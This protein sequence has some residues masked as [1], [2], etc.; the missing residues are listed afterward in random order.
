[1][2]FDRLF[3]WFICLG[4]YLFCFITVLGASK[5][6]VAKHR[7]KFPTPLGK[8]NTALLLRAVAAEVKGGV[9]IKTSGNNCEGISCDIICFSDGRGFDVLVDSE[10]QAIPAWNPV[11]NL[12]KTK[13]QLI[14]TPDPIPIP[15]DPTQIELLKE[16]RDLL[17]EI[18]NLLL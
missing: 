9:Y 1:M 12:D 15:G 10:G 2:K 17:K 16:I 6:I 8:A 11:S 18:R 3:K 7:A 5:D 14:T 4:L 13:C